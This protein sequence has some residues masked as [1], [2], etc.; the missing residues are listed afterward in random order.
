MVAASQLLKKTPPDLQVGL[1]LE[2]EVVGLRRRGQAGWDFRDA[3]MDAWW[4]GGCDFDGFS[5]Q[6]KEWKHVETL[7]I[8]WKLIEDLRIDIFPTCILSFCWDLAV[9]SISNYSDVL[10][11]NS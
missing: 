4:V 3:V 9:F 10:N 1:E 5:Q 7:N 2:E 11:N 8:S 6:Q